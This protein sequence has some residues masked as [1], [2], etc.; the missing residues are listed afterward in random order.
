MTWKHVGRLA[1]VA[2]P[3][4]IVASLAVA[5]VPGGND[6]LRATPASANR[7]ASAAAAGRRGMAAPRRVANLKRQ[8]AKAVLAY[9]TPRRMRAAKPVGRIL[10]AKP[11]TMAAASPTGP[12]GGGGGFV[13]G[14]LRA[15]ARSVPSAKPQSANRGSPTPL[16]GSYPG[17][18]D[19]WAYFSDY[20]QYPVSTLGKL[21]FHD[22]VGGGNFSC[23]AGVTVGDAS[24]LDAV[25]TAGHCVANG[26]HAQ[27]YDSWL[28]CPSYQN[29]PNPNLGC[30]S[31]AGA[32]TTAAWYY[33]GTL[34]RDFAVIWMQGCGTVICDHIAN[35]TGGL[36]FSWNWSR[37]QHWI[38]MGYPADPN[39]PFDGQSLQVCATEHRYDDGGQGSPATN[40]WG[41]DQ[42]HGASGSP[43]I[44]FFGRANWINSLVSYG[45][46][47]Q[48]GELYGPYQDTAACQLWQSWTNWQGTC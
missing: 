34:A 26:G 28:F 14:S 24:Q 9:W 32:D 44:L 42:S 8:S 1:F 36:G 7:Q 5:L 18:F 11:Q 38:H 13:P 10:S 37:D 27:Y 29:G 6:A 4:A 25:W 33:D 3:I 41:C 40:S 45:Y 20:T 21:F 15:T 17:P 31:W 19:R 12:A 22:P 16:D 35:V 2:V 46:D 47:G 30:W 43:L 23:S 39:P 48:P